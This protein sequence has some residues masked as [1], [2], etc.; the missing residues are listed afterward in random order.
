MTRFTADGRRMNAI[1]YVT[2]QM[3]TQAWYRRGLIRQGGGPIL[4]KRAS[5]TQN[6]DFKARHGRQLTG[7]RCSHRLARKPHDV[8]MA[9]GWGRWV[10]TQAA[11]QLT[12]VPT[13]RV[14][15]LALSLLDG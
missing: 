4:G 6:I 15:K 10:S 12:W 9:L 8:G 5:C 13:T 14:G 1:T 7:R 11:A 3:T 2:K